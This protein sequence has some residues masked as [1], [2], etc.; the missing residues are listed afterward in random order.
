[1]SRA[2]NS[3]AI[4]T[5][6][7]PNNHVEIILFTGAKMRRKVSFDKIQENYFK[8]KA[9]DITAYNIG[10]AWTTSKEIRRY[11]KYLRKQRDTKGT[12]IYLEPHE[13]R[14]K[15]IVDNLVKRKK[16]QEIQINYIQTE[17]NVSSGDL[18]DLTNDSRYQKFAAGEVSRRRV[19]KSS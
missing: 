6:R 17:K 11:F 4:D 19:Q 18:A 2:V 5:A 14:I 1:M 16:Y 7:N 9:S 3:A 10:K 12:I 8:T 13:E 15:T